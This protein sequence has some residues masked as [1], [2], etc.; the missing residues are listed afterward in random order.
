MISLPLWCPYREA[1]SDAVSG[2]T[3][4]WPPLKAAV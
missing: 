1:I 3:A 4:F 2:T